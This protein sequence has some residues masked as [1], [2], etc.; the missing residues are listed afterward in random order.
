[1]YLELALH[2]N[3]KFIKQFIELNPAILQNQQAADL[4][5]SIKKNKSSR[6]KRN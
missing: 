6:T 2:S 3:T 5:A 1:V 4:I